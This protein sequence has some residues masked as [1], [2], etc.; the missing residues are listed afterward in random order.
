MI[1][2][3]LQN[4]KPSA[5]LAVSA[6]A[7]ELKAK[8]YDIIS[9]SAGEPDF[10][11]PEVICKA[12]IHAINEGMTHYTAVPGTLNLRQA[13]VKKLI[14]DNHI[15]YT[16]DDIIVSNGAKQSIFNAIAAVI[17]PGDEVIIPSPYWVSYP[18]MV[19][20]N[21]GTPVICKPST[22][23]KPTASD[24]E[25]Y[26]TPKTKMLILN[27]PNNPG[28]YTISKAELQKI[29]DLLENHPNI[30]ILTDDIYEYLTWTEEPFCNIINTNPSLKERTILINGASKGYAMTGW[31]IGYTA[32][33]NA[34]INK[35]M[36]TFQSQ[37]TSCPSAISQFA[38]IAAM[39]LTR[40][41]LLPMLEEYQKRHAILFAGLNNIKGIKAQA[42]EGA[43]YSFPDCSGLI[44]HLGLQDDIEFAGMLL[45]KA[46]LAVVP[47]SA[48]GAKNH[49]R[50]SF[51]C[52]EENIRAALERLNAI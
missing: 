19:A 45:E 15:N 13:I 37:T 46:N 2:N 40:Q 27:S 48:F 28:G 6:K 51:A 29:G 52:S 8:G 42:C 11:T 38:T 20:I 21:S 18:D 7:N 47:G 23:I 5:T 39:E 25:K 32:C 35:A 31:R 26:I 14:R 36:K 10:A 16:P 30:V 50:L 44:E 1:A 17:N 24:I 34:A 12:G 49:I 33:S 3:R 22:G 41:D 9:L 43:F 4:I